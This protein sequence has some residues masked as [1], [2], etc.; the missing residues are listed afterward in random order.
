MHLKFHCK[1][2][3]PIGR[4]NECT[5]ID[6]IILWAWWLPDKKTETCSLIN[7]L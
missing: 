1:Q 3:D 2:W 6:N 4:V 7:Q 5:L